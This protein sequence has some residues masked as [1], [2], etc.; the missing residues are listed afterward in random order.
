MNKIIIPIVF[1]GTLA[2]CTT[3]QVT[4]L[5]TATA[6]VISTIQA[7]VATACE[8]F[9]DAADVASIF[10]STL[11]AT[12]GIVESAICSAAPPPASAAFKKLPLKVSGSAEVVVGTVNGTVIHGWRLQ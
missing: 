9:P 4:A 12:I 6:S 3:A 10:N 1:A 2:A 7:G 5:N 11:G 8:I